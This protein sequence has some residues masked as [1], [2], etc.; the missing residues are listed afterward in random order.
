ML[1]LQASI[2]VGDVNNDG[3]LDVV[4]GNWGGGYKLYLNNGDGTFRFR[5]VWRRNANQCSAVGRRQQ[6]W[7]PRHRGG[8]LEPGRQVLYQ[9]GSGLTAP[10]KDLGQVRVSVTVQI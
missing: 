4:A 10:G 5:P 7:I 3:H 1:T 6:R 9:P 2:Q 8:K